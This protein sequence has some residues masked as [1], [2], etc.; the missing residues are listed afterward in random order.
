MKMK[1]HI[2]KD[3]LHIHNIVAFN[4]TIYYISAVLAV[5]LLLL[6][7]FYSCTSTAPETAGTERNDRE[8]KTELTFK[9]DKAVKGY[10]DI[11]YFN[12]DRLRKLDSYMRAELGGSRRTESA[13]RAGKKILVTIANSPL[14]AEEYSKVLAYDDLQNLYAELKSE[15]PDAPVM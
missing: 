5:T 7:V 6:P 15:N 12:D 14:N 4:L 9:T 13:S 10:I 11:L 3:R 1:N 8:E 2:K